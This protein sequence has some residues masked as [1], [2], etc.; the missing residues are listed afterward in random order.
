M[1]V[2]DQWVGC[3]GIYNLDRMNTAA[4]R[5]RPRS[6]EDQDLNS[7]RPV[8][9]SVTQAEACRETSNH[10]L[11]WEGKLKCVA[12]A[13]FYGVNTPTSANFKLST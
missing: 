2:E 1:Q 6:Q 11:S 13:D 9:R 5:N 4:E 8:P 12:S 10:Q 7:G 3:W